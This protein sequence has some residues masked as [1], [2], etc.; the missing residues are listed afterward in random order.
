MNQF[1]ENFFVAHVKFSGY[2]VG[3]QLSKKFQRLPAEVNVVPVVVFL[4]EHLVE[5]PLQG[6]SQQS[7]DLLEI[8]FDI[9]GGQGFA[10]TYPGG[11]HVSVYL[12]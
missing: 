5:L 12:S 6:L 9:E 10:A 4:V 3:A 7:Y 2:F 8:A 11:R 1:E